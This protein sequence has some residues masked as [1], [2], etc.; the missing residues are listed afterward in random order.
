MFALYKSTLVN[1]SKGWEQKQIIQKHFYP[2]TTGVA[3]CVSRGTSCTCKRVGQGGANKNNPKPVSQVWDHHTQRS[4]KWLKP[5]QSQT[6]NHCTV[7]DIQINA[8][9]QSS[10]S[11]M[12]NKIPAISCKHLQS[13]Y[14]CI[15]RHNTAKILYDLHNWGE[16]KVFVYKC[17]KDLGMSS[18]WFSMKR[19]QVSISPCHSTDAHPPHFMMKQMWLLTF[20]SLKTRRKISKG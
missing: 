20:A 15:F 3:E 1:W 5:S 10:K 11:E 13:C 12:R 16:K 14:F 19:Q 17:H 18:S 4:N 7:V 9:T 8:I 2:N 6:R